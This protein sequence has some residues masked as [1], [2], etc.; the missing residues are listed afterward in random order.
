MSAATLAAP[1]RFGHQAPPH[2]S[3]AN[4]FLHLSRVGVLSGAWSITAG[5]LAGSLGSEPRTQR[6]GRR[7]GSVVLVSR[8]RTARADPGR[9]R[10]EAPGLCPWWPRRS[11]LGDV[12]A[13]AATRALVEGTAP[14]SS[15]RRGCAGG[16]R[17]ATC[18]PPA[19]TGQAPHR[20][21]AA[22]Q[23]A[24]GRR[25]AQCHRHLSRG[26]GAGG[27]PGQPLPRLVVGRPG[28]RR[29]HAASGIA[30]AEATPGPPHPTRRNSTE[31]GPRRPARRSRWTAA[32]GD[33]SGR[34][35]APC[36]HRDRR[37]HLPRPDRRSDRGAGALLRR[38]RGR[39]AQR[40]RAAR[41]RRSGSHGDGL[42]IGGRP[43]RHANGSCP[44]TAGTATPTDR[45]VTGPTTCCPPSSRRRLTLPV[46]GGRIALG[47]WQ[48]VVLVDLNEDNPRR[49]VRLSFIPAADR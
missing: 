23:R 26:A 44:A 24:P 42:G 19:R 34:L 49:R 45:W 11:S 30:A 4:P 39:P 32:A 6:P 10:A 12:I 1:D 17:L 21:L 27:P 3:R 16:P 35:G 38:Q 31:A 43:G 22:K 25:D 2:P 33:R 8:F 48:S 7:C 5:L 40:L 9:H 14:M 15:S 41:H 28:W 47:T 46:L 13:V 29:W 20:N 18:S 36:R 37:R